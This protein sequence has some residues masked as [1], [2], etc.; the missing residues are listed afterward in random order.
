MEKGYCSI[1]LHAHL[2]FVRHPEHN[3][4]L[5]EDWFYEALTESYIPFIKM[6]E[7]LISD[8]ID[9]RLTLSLSP[10]LLSMMADPLLQ[11]RY[12]SK[13]NKLIDLSYQEMERTSQQPEYNIL[14]SHYHQTFLE[15]REL[16]EKKYHKNLIQLFKC[17]QDKGK[18]E[19]I[20]SCAT[21]AFLPLLNKNH[22]AIKAQIQIGLEYYKKFLGIKPKGFWLPEC[23]Y[24]LGLDEVLK[25]FGLRYF[26]VEAHGILNAKPRPKHGVFAP[27]LCPSG[28]AAFGRDIDS[29]KQVWSSHYGYPGDPY[30]RDF[31][32]D[33]GYDLKYDYIKPFLHEDGLRTYTGIKYYRITGGDS[34]DKEPY[35][36]DVARSKTIEHADNFI[37]NR[38]KQSEYLFYF[39]GRR[40]IIVTPFDAELFGHW[41]YEGP[42]WLDFVMRKAACS[43]KT[44]CMIT[45]SEFLDCYP[46]NQV[47]TP[48]QSSWGWKGYNES[49]LDKSND[50]IYR[51][52]HK[53][54]E[55]MVTLAREYPAAN[56]ILLR[57]LN[58]AARELLLAQSSDWAFIMKTGTVANY[59]IQR[60]KSHLSNFFHLR[61]SL[62]KGKVDGV[63]L[64]DLE[65]QHNI[66]PDIDYRIYG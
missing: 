24:E 14:A 29:S 56:G 19:I 64:H 31:Y 2:P 15:S 46:E 18:L 22:V 35:R 54:A 36:P 60:T 58:Q 66:F 10:T 27:V 8:N 62:L 21:H 5:E 1:V 34:V 38:E 3:S 16:F 65:N 17:F 4:F 48:S 25:D 12:L 47:S 44:F 51:H 42:Q 37:V 33:I 59:A 40:P 20:T 39:L 57:A 9:F 50:W 53:A 13:L 11:K 49:W 23:G 30:Y 32:R 61:E 45:P 43:Q 26:F 55:W 63:W 28:V 6:M 52:L 7:G 41:W